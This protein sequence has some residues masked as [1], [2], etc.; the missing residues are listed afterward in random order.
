MLVSPLSG[1]IAVPWNPWGIAAPKEQPPPEPLRQK[2]R[3]RPKTL[4]SRC[5]DSS[6]QHLTDGVNRPSAKDHASVAGESLRSNRQRGDRLGRLR[7]RGRANYH[8]GKT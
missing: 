8:R 1:E 4:E 5:R 2:D 7:C 3:P 6:P